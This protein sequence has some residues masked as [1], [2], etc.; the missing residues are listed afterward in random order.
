MTLAL[1][2]S[3]LIYSRT[4]YFYETRSFIVWTDLEAAVSRFY[5]RSAN[6]HNYAM[7]SLV[8]INLFLVVT[9]ERPPIRLTVGYVAGHIR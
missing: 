2:K 7:F 5:L 8:V 4:Q 9:H 3:N 1:V 6:C